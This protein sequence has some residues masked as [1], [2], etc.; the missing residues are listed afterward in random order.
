LWK[1]AWF[2]PNSVYPDASD[3]LVFPDAFFESGSFT[4]QGLF[5]DRLVSVFAPLFLIYA[6]STSGLNAVAFLEL[7]IEQ[8]G[9]G[10]VANN[11]ILPPSAF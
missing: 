2:E 8:M 10:R 7:M 6:S 4:F 9:T 3:P 1:E 11:V 5:S